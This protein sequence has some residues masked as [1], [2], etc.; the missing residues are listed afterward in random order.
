MRIEVAPAEL[1]RAA[2]RGRSGLEEVD[3]AFRELRRRHALAD[4]LGRE[5]RRP[6][7]G[8]RLELVPHRDAHDR[9]V[10]PGRRRHRFESLVEGRP[11]AGVR[12]RPR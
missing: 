3:A 1:G 10:G 11:R 8:R 6:R 12:H 7:H 5:R 2:R 4:E 9:E